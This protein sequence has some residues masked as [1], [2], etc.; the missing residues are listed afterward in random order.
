VRRVMKRTWSIRVEGE[1]LVYCP[2][3]ACC[4]IIDTGTVPFGFALVG[5]RHLPL[6]LSVASRLCFSGVY[7][8]RVGLKK[9]IFFTVHQ[10]FLKKIRT[11][12][13]KLCY[14]VM[15]SVL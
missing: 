10:L 9:N 11:E 8:E 6:V 15:L 13:C 12:D 2:L 5:C 14:N 4:P 3:Q 1:P 7:R